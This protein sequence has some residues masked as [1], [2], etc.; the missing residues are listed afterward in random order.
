MQSRKALAGFLP[1]LLFAGCASVALSES[2]EVR[3]DLSRRSR[4][5]DSIRRNP[6]WLSHKIRSTREK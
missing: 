5:Q 2:G 1:V 4:L 6:E 3:N